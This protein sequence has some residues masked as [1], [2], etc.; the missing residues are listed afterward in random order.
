MSGQK[1]LAYRHPGSEVYPGALAGRT[2]QVD[3]YS[4]SLGCSSITQTLVPWGPGLAGAL[5]W[6]SSL[7]GVS[8]LIFSSWS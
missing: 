1:G 8:T 4:L 6:L 7:V 2:L 3:I 5:A